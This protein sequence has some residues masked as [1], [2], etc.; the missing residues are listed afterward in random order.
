[1]GKNEY[2]DLVLIANTL[3]NNVQVAT[4]NGVVVRTF[5]CKYPCSVCVD[6][7]TNNVFV[8]TWPIPREFGIPS[9]EQPHSV[10]SVFSWNDSTVIRE[11]SDGKQW[12]TP[13]GVAF[14]D[15][16][17]QLFVCDDVNNRI[18]VFTPEGRPVHR[19]TFVSPHTGV[20]YSQCGQIC[21]NTADDTTF[22]VCAFKQQIVA[23]KWDG[24]QETLLDTFMLKTGSVCGI[25]SNPVDRGDTI[26]AV[27]TPNAF[28]EI[29]Y[30]FTIKTRTT[31][32]VFLACLLL[33]PL[34]PSL[35][36]R[37]W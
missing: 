8:S 34:T 31:R 23:Y 6:G 5:D 14:N 28:D 22:M 20:S 21:V 24:K 33:Q 29:P 7:N 36:R 11:I 18:H 15:E 12:K 37:D 26:A 4:M 3:R 30:L 27:V 10:I 17:N 16:H 13:V 1:M 19:F 2:S 35:T 25:A 32:T 9:D